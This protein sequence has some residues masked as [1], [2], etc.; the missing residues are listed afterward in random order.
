MHF[1]KRPK[2]REKR[3]GGFDDNQMCTID[4]VSLTASFC[5]IYVY[6]TVYILY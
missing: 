5:S 4:R 1:I 3:G 6:I 2:C